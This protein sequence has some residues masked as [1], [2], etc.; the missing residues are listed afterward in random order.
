MNDLLI[1]F[2]AII[3]IASSI[4]GTLAGFGISTIMLPIMVL[5]IP[6]QQALLIVGIISIF[7]DIS[8]MIFF[9]QGLHW[10]LLLTFGISGIIASFLGARFSVLLPTDIPI[11]IL[12]LFLFVYSYYLLTN[13]SLKLPRT[14]R[15]EVAVGGISG[16]LS[17]LIGLGGDTRGPFLA[18]FSLSKDVYIFTAGAIGFL[19][20][21]T[22]IGT[23]LYQGHSTSPLL[24]W[25]LFIFIPCS[26]IGA[27]F[28]KQFASKI[29]EQRFRQF[30]S[31]ILFIIAV[32]LMI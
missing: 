24:L 30:A 8:R 22:R 2:I 19:I 18:P 28:A 25:G 1:P 16:F 14:K 6:Y 27:F 12:G 3:T 29:P 15:A 26:F 21:S 5:I 20:D 4:I 23:Y 17:G 10:R 11:R 7:G 9:R 13:Q 32:K 31:G